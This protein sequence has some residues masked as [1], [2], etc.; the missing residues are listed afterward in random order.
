[1]RKCEIK[2]A[3]AA[4]IFLPLAGCVRLYRRALEV[5]FKTATGVGQTDQL[6]KNIRA[7]IFKR[8]FQNIVIGEPNADALIIVIVLDDPYVTFP[9]H[10]SPPFFFSPCRR[11]PCERRKIQSEYRRQEKHPRTESFRR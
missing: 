1:M 10:H 5:P 7:D 6:V 8:I 11:V 3:S 2:R 4:E 9:R